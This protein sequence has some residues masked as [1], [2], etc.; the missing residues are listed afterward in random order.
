MKKLYTK[1]GIKY[2][3]VADD[4]TVVTIP[5]TNK[6]DNDK[7]NSFI[8]S[9]HSLGRLLD[10][11]YTSS[12]N[13]S[14]AVHQFFVDTLRKYYNNNL[15]TKIKLI[16]EC[17]EEG[18]LDYIAGQIIVTNLGQELSSRYSLNIESILALIEK[19]DKGGFF[20]Q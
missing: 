17:I 15:D 3:W 6:I 19:I 9:A 1:D 14:N 5:V 7:D 20:D 2:D 18:I 8:T 16:G 11:K 13:E 4:S 12:V 10:K